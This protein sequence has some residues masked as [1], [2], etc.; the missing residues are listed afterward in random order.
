MN[1]REAIEQNNSNLSGYNGNPLI[2]A[3]SEYPN[4][5][6]NIPQF[7]FNSHLLKDYN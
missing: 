1:I 2:E 6:N 4:A 7:T 3:Q 5:M